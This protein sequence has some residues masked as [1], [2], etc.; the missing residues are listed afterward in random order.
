MA[1]AYSASEVMKMKKRV[2]P[3]TGAWA[4]AFGQPERTGIWFV[5]GQSGNGKTGFLMQLAKE[6][7]K[8]GRVAYD[9]LEQGTSLSMQQTLVQ[10]RMEETGGRFLLLT[11][12]SIEELDARMSKP[13]SPDFYMVDSFQYTGLS[14]AEYA[15][16]ASRHRNK[17]VIFVSQAEG[18]NPDGRTARKVMFDA[19]QK[20]FVE[21]FKAVSKGRFFGPKGH[22]IIWEEGAERYW[23]RRQRNHQGD[24][25]M[26]TE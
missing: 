1:R 4:E 20:I 16:F 18:R 8:F 5:W 6:L 15:D 17:L 21:G 2:I 26:E 3:F 25:R 24:N 9:S 10:N 7:C 11:R 22:Y 19:D 12:E 13:K 14:A 23:G